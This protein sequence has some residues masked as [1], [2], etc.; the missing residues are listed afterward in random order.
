FL[1]PGG[2]II[3]ADPGRAYVQKFI[4]AM[5]EL[6]Y[7]ERFTTQT[8][9]ASLTSNNKQRDIFIFEFSN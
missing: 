4:T 9:L 1:K 7:K 8:V 5:N 6:G 2:K 3:L